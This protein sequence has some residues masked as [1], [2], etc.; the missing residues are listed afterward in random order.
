MGQQREPT[1]ELSAEGQS[2]GWG[3]RWGILDIADC[4]Y[5]PSDLRQHMLDE[6]H[7]DAVEEGYRD[8]LDD[9]D[10]LDAADA[11]MAAQ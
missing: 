10:D 1:E 8:A 11:A 9:S 6:P 7:P 5:D 4:E 3:V 2:Y